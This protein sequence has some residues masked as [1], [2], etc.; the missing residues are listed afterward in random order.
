MSITFEK[1]PIDAT[2]ITIRV[3]DLSDMVHDKGSEYY[4]AN[5]L[6]ECKIALVHFFKGHRVNLRKCPICRSTVVIR[7]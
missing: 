7:R 1:N 6:E 5:S 3:S 2:R 4:N